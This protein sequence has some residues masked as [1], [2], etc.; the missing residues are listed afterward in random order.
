MKD[1][2]KNINYPLLNISYPYWD[3]YIVEHMF[4]VDNNFR[5]TN[6]EDYTKYFLNQ[7][8]VDCSGNIYRIIDKSEKKIFGFVIPNRGKFRFIETEKKMTFTDVKDYI[9]SRIEQEKNSDIK[10]IWLEYIDKSST[11]EQI[12]SNS[13]F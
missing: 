13:N 7:E 11:I 12:I 4:L 9:K 10:K 2:I 3:E 6:L 5:F 8:Y 1:F